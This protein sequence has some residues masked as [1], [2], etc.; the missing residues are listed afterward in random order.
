MGARREQGIGALAR[1]RGVL[2][3]REMKNV[4]AK[5]QRSFPN[6]VCSLFWCSMQVHS[7]RAAQ[8]R[9][10]WTTAVVSAIVPQGYLGLTENAPRFSA[11]QHL[12]ALRMFVSHFMNM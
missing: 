7:A 12:W 11:F 8:A 6:K 2:P 5:N 1:E 9:P 4:S 10:N 3:T